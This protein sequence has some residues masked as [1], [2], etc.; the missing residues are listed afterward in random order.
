[1]EIIRLERSGHVAHLI[2]NRPERKNAFNAAMWTALEQ[3]TAEIRADLP[4]V[5]VVSG[6]PL[7]GFSSGFDVNPDNP[8]VVQ[9]MQALEQSD[10][11][12][13]EALIARM[14]TAIDTLTRL[15][16]P[17]IA[18]ITGDAFGGGAELAI[19]CDMRIMSAD[20]RICFS[21]VTLGLMPDWG[22]GVALARLAGRARA[23]ELILSAEPVTAT[24]A[25][26]MGLA[27][28][29]C[30]PDDVVSQA[31]SLASRIAANG[32]GA[33]RRAL[34]IIRDT[35]DLPQQAALDLESAR[36]VDLIMTGECVH[37]I[38]AFL[39]DKKAEFPEPEKNRTS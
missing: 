4:R 35:P 27:N 23:A 37:G 6:N 10:R 25:A 2:L 3:R 36:A 1:M 21:E 16:I 19:R 17:V 34:S 15:P 38:T 33:V 9:F 28:R 39:S 18:A 11:H 29:L 32:P 31:M 26:A 24:A 14:R 5:L 12:P 30:P 13:A 20:A 22:G 8:M 7:G